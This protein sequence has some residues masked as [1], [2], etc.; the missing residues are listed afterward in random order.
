MSQVDIKPSD[1]MTMLERLEIWRQAKLQESKASKKSSPHSNQ[2]RKTFALSMLP[3]PVEGTIRAKRPPMA[4]NGKRARNTISK[5]D[6]LLSPTTDQM[7]AMSLSS[8][9]PCQDMRRQRLQNSN[10]WN[11]SPPSPI[12][13]GSVNASPHANK[14]SKHVLCERSP[15][16]NDGY[17]TASED[18]SDEEESVSKLYKGGK[19]NTTNGNIQCYMRDKENMHNHR[20]SPGHNQPPSV[21]KSIVLS[22]KNTN[23]CTPNKSQSSSGGC[24]KQSK[25]GN[26][27]DKQKTSVSALKDKDAT[28][29]QLNKTISK[30][31]KSLEAANEEVKKMKESEEVIRF[32]NENLKIE[33]KSHQEKVQ[34]YEA[35]C[36]LAREDV[37][38]MAFANSINEQRIGE[39]ELLITK[40][41]MNQNEHNNKRNRKYK[42]E[43]ERLDK[44]KVEYEQR[45]NAMISQLQTQMCS[46]QE[47]AMSRIETL[48]KDLM[49]TQR[50]N[51]DL[52]NQVQK[53]NNNL[54]KRQSACGTRESMCGGRRQSSARMSTAAT[55]RQ[56]TFLPPPL[57]EESDED[58]SEGE[59]IETEDIIENSA[60][61]SSPFQSEFDDMDDLIDPIY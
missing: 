20:G 4:L 43:Y 48:E 14:N 34:E 55:R 49:E 50:K 2:R 24:F 1:K 21:Q 28:I 30:L 42:E 40:S 36:D 15:S 37:E 45:A 47:S 60:G 35:R 18:L 11:D 46:L 31:T 32:S 16:N 8:P 29:A 19:Y 17:V 59:E 53:A 6:S 22:P 10:G 5:T 39:L 51:E 38:A 54:N 7:S 56:S 25:Q 33:L 58:S 27:A 44:D 61:P 23:I 3:S 57:L 52:T 13:L 26:S 9:S 41:R 12:Q